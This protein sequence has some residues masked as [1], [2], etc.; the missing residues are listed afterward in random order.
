[1]NTET[2]EAAV[3]FEPAIHSG[4]LD[5]HDAV[6]VP[7]GDGPRPGFQS[8][9]LRDIRKQ[10]V[11]GTVGQAVCEPLQTFRGYMDGIVER[12]IDGRDHAGVLQFRLRLELRGLDFVPLQDIFGAYVP[13][14]LNVIKGQ[15][16][17]IEI[18]AD[19]GNEA[20]E[21]AQE[22]DVMLLSLLLIV[23]VRG[24]GAMSIDLW[25]ISFRA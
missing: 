11:A 8:D 23:I 9:T 3:G 12:A 4:K 20:L 6:L 5:L 17:T 22:C 21:L 16:L 13:P 2:G 15:S 14:D 25:L 7:G 24:S 19:G 18:V 10:I 1:M